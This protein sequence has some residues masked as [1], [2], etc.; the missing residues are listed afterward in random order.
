M[1]KYK[2]MFVFFGGDKMERQILHI[3][4]NSFYASVE[5]AEN[6]EIKD[7]PVA[8]VGDAEKRHGI[9]LTAN[10]IAKLG[11]E[12]KTAE[13]VYSAL[14][15]CP[16][17]VMIKANMPLYMEYS[18]KMRD[19][20]LEYTDLVEGFGCDENFAD[21]THSVKLFGSGEEIAKKIS[22]RIKN[23]LKITVS[24]GVSFNKV[25]AKLGSD[26]KKPDG[27]TVISKENFKDVVWNLDAGKLLYVGRKTLQKLQRRGIYTI[28]DIANAEIGSLK[29]SLGKSGEML[30]VYANGYDSEPVKRFDDEKEVKSISNSV[31]TSR[32]LDSIEDVKMIIYN[33]ADSVA[34]RAR[35]KGVKGNVV[36]LYIKDENFNSLVRQIKLDY[37]TDT[38][39]EIANTAIELFKNNY[40]WAEDVRLLGV[41]ISGFFTESDAE[42]MSVFD[43][44]KNR[45]KIRVLEETQDKLKAKFGFDCVKR[46]VLMQDEKLTDN[47]FSKRRD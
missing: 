14:K 33:L 26:M 35:K 37:H 3:D 43:D 21:V 28:G 30:Y 27:I 22:D 42:Q 6:P 29:A 38:S 2:Q 44:T 47:H 23:E 32:N 19:I 12:I 1:I 20:I 5:C 25:F 41:G 40:N 11:F 4:A 39:R 13:T 46:A 17:L 9:V 7:K 34:Y 16:D 18:R 24:I 36:S 8:V 45:E 31:T 15:K 10:Y